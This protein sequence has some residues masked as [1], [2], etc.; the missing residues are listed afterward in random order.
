MSFPKGKIGIHGLIFG[1]FAILICAVFPAFAQAQTADIQ[2]ASQSDSPDPSPAGGVV[3]YTIVVANNGGPNQATGVTLTDTL[4]T[5]ATFVSAAATQGSCS[6]PAGGTLSCSLG[7]ISING[8]ATVTVQVRIPTA[9]TATNTVQVSAN[10]TDPNTA[11]NNDNETTTIVSAADMTLSVVAPPSVN[12]GQPYSYTVTPTN[13]GPDGLVATDTQT[14]SFTVPNGSCITSTPTG[15]GWSCTPTIN[16]STPLCN[17]GSNPTISCTRT[18]ALASGNN[19]PALNVPAV[20]N[21]SGTVTAAFNVSSS[22]PDGNPNN[23]TATVNTTV[24]GGSSDL[25]ISKAASPNTTV[26]VGG[27]VTYTLTPRFNGGVPPGTASPNIITVTDTLGAGLTYVSASG[28]GWTC[29]V[30]GSTITC[31]R[32]GPY[33]GGNYTNMP[34]LSVVATATT[35]GTLAN[36]ASISAPETDPNPVNNTAAVN[37]TGSNDADLQMTKTAS[38]N[39][40]VP[41]QNFNYSLTV[42]NLGPLNIPAGQT[43][44]VTD[45]L[46]AGLTLTAAPSGSGWTCTPNSGFPIAGPVI[47]SCTRPGPLAINTNAPVITLPVVANTTNTLTN[48]ACTSLSG[49]GPVDPNS[50]NNCAGVGISSTT[51]QADLEVTSKIASPDPVDA[52]QD[53]TYTINVRNNGPDSSTNVI[54]TDTLG[55]LIATGGFQSATP[56]QGTCT[57]SGVTSSSSVTLSC[58]LGTLAVGG[59]ATITVVIR[60]SIATTGNRTNTATVTSRDVGDPDRTN[61]SKTVTSTIT[62]IADVTVGKTATPSP[63][64]AGTELT[65]VI[66]ARNAG[67]ST[68]SSVTIT[69][70]LPINAAFVSVGTPSG[71]GTCGTVPAVGTVGGTLVCSWSSLTGSGTGSQRTVRVVVRPLTSAA[72]G[73]VV[74]NVAVTT[75]TK[76]SNSTNND[77]NVI[78]PVTAALVDL[79]INKTDSVDPIALGQ[80]TQYTIS[81][82]NNGPSYATNVSLTDTFPDGGV[83]S[84]TFSYQG[85]LTISPTGAGTCTEPALNATTGPLNCTFTGIAAGQTVTVKYTMRAESLDTAGA[86]SGTTFNKAA[87]TATEPETLTANNTTIQGT[88]TRVPVDLVLTKSGPTSLTPGQAFDWTLNVTNNGPNPSTGAVVTDI[89]PAGVTYQSAS[90]GCT[91]T[92]ATRTVRCTLGTLAFPGSTSLTI[93]VVP[94]SPYTGASP[95]LNTAS[96]ATV[97]EVDTVPG[98]NSGSS[99]TPV[100]NP[101]A[102]VSVVKSSTPNP[103]VPGQT[104]TYTVVV[105]NA[106]PSAA[107]NARFSDTLPAAL[108]SFPWTCVATT[109]SSCPASG[110]GN[111]SNQAVTVR[112]GGK[113]TYTFTGIVPSGTTGQLLNTATVTAP[114][115]TTDPTPGNN[116]APNDN[117]S[118]IKVDLSAKKTSTPKPYIPGQTLTYTVE[119]RNA[120]PSDAVGAT[121]SDPL[122]TALAGFSWTCSASTGSSCTASGSGN[123]TD[124]VTVRAG[125]LL[126]YTISGTV[127]SGTTGELA[128]T[129]TVTPTAGTNETD[130]SNNSA[131]DRNSGNIRADLSVLKSSAPD[132][133]VPGQTLTYTVVVNNAGPSDAVDATFSDTLPTAL[134]NFPWTCLATTGSSCPASGTGNISNQTVTVLAAGKLT[135]T[136][137]GIVPSGTTGQLK[138][139]AAI[140]PSA[141]TTDPTPTNNTAGNDNPSN[142]KVDL[143]AAKRGTP[144]P[145]VPGQTLSYTLEIRN[146]GPSDAVNAL[147]SDPLPTAFS[148]FTWTCSASTGS[149]C[150]ASGSGGIADTVTVRA[151]GL[152]TYTIQGVVPAGLRSDQTNN[153]TV[154]PA[155]GTNDTNLANNTATVVNGSGPIADLSVIKNSRPDPYVPGQILTY[156]VVVSNAGPSDA[157]GTT[158][159][160]TLPTVFSG[161]SW[162]CSASVGSRCAASG[163][164]NISDTVNLLAGGS[165]T[166]T[167]S[168]TVP[169]G[170]TGVQR[171]TAAVSA[172]T[173]TTDPTPTNNTAVNQNPSRVTVDLSATKRSDPSSY[174]PGQL[175]TYTVEIRNS[176]PSDAISALVSDPLPTAFAGFTWTC[177]ASTGSRCAPSGTGPVT[178]TAD[179]L[180]GGLL[181]YT[182]RGTVPTSTSG[183]KTNSVTVTPPSGANDTNLANNTA[184]VSSSGDARADLSVVKSSN[185]D[186]YVPGQPLTYTLVVS[187]AGPSDTVNA[188]VTDT[189]PAA[190]SAF[191]W[192]CTATTGSRC[193]A[194][195]TG[196]ISDTVNV[197]AGGSLTYKITGIVPSGTTG[198]V[199]NTAAVNPPTGTTDPAPGN[200]SAVNDNPSN[201]K[202]DLSAA[203]R[204][205]P[206]PYIPGRQLTYTVEV[207]NAGPSDAVDAL[208]SDPMP[209]AFAGFTWTC[210]ASTGS[211]CAASGSGGITDTVTVRAG[212]LLTYT[213]QGVVPSG[214]AGVQTNTVTVTP[215]A[216]ANEVNPNNNSASD[217]N[218]TGSQADLSVIK[219]SS[220]DPYVSGQPLTYTVVVSNAG[221][222][223]AVGTTVTDTLPSALAGFG[224]TCSASAGSRCTAS[225]SGSINDTVNLRAGGSLTY[226][227][228]GTV[229]S[230]TTGQLRNTATVVPPAGTADPA[231]SNNTA[232]NDNPSTNKVDLSATK[233]SSPN[234]YVVGQRLTYLIEIRNSGPSDAINALVSDPLPNAFAGFGWGCIASA[235]SRCAVSGSGSISDTVTVLSGGSITYTVSGTVP[236]GT[237]GVQ[238]NTVTVTP[239]PG[240]N[241]TNPSNN[242]A[243][244]DNP[245]GP[246]ADLSIHKSSSPDP[247][248]PGQELTYTVVVSNAGPSDVAGAKVTDTLPAAFADFS[249]SCLASTGN[250]CTASGRGSLNDT[251]DIRAHGTLTYTFKGRVPSGTTATQRNTATVTPPAGITDPST[252]N[253][254]VINDNPSTSKVDLS[255]VKYSTPNPY[256]PG[257]T[258]TYTLQIRNA[259]PSDAVNALVSDPLPT[260]FAGF[261]WTCAASS[262]SRCG[263]S[264]RGGISATVTI[265]AEGL[266][267]YKVSGLV[268]MNTQGIQ[269]NTVT[270]SP[271]VGVNDAVVKNNVASDTTDSTDPTEIPTLSQ[272]A[273]FLLLVSLLLLAGQAL[274]WRGLKGKGRL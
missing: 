254:T 185:P 204:G 74:N 201:I 115:G 200:N 36:T 105:N 38:I 250:R 112:A 67:P 192:T 114:T 240:I 117:P 79:L 127:P 29:S 6:P 151:G 228:T 191:T 68:A 89:L 19:A 225:G 268:P 4:P 120:G 72:G 39:P 84:A 3:T 184:S 175:L 138:N 209:T 183:V 128:N 71:G 218:R 177:T 109:G 163:T 178:D 2:I 44:T 22:M 241:D 133:Y 223:D 33:T 78:T 31:T 66:T 5:G 211:R 97:N 187:N 157:L 161:F 253:N 213:V 70:T 26:A 196:N 143:S 69:D 205:T 16:S 212:G 100:G 265:L 154:T 227:I 37:V 40:V 99:S 17:T 119:I 104:L 116:T 58:N 262:G 239:P 216:G 28:S 45:T 159:T 148:G 46:P 243:S 214:T 83:K 10:E 8:S 266:L 172:P 258:L 18:G 108:A 132:P 238:T 15:V 137:T 135:Y 50:P 77:A 85:G 255:A 147:V 235:G 145:Y 54:V 24:N 23:N 90:P 96:V 251:V 51:T 199:R 59:T 164:G 101:V 20:A 220:P 122:P 232:A 249:W 252:P 274:T 9:G 121:V 150:A 134:V 156:T 76:E 224:W 171:N 170:T 86:I 13:N 130:A 169:A 234:P 188:I 217:T 82:T 60:P 53:L 179:V 272:W 182:I 195:G 245:T 27:N 207:G 55:S 98:N 65:Y 273:A 129:V 198:Q 168:G 264:G 237:S 88:S 222:S 56:S 261:T 242:T 215:P 111:I 110:T 14:I 219:S 233:R 42:R 263:A 11:N 146:A 118:D 87:V 202:V 208:V 81:I 173:G 165:L 47:I 248:I 123:I 141:G 34:T 174:I 247:Y 259:G 21:V 57:P 25:L 180:A 176:G 221:P 75:T 106:G 140:N 194:S 230:G 64:R 166:Y 226:T 210:S 139:T 256:V 48:N 62:A 136:F 149:H 1:W 35:T 125:G 203:K 155:P 12:A 124:T 244:N 186:P 91:Y 131:T 257:Q 236:L 126:T 41:G 197:R 92:T 246:E 7:N 94:S 206:N 73:N 260:A 144:N 153:V 93:R 152:L 189:L 61:N 167:L 181:T 160:D 269:S 113:L 49:T 231:G 80:S 190:F 107:V 271:P 63:V 158:V 52:G 32:P 95:L 103:Y 102:D 267:T 142:I 30:S 162:T 43:I 229:P 270:V 193:T